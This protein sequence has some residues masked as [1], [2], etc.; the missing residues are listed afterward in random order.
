MPS[1]GVVFPGDGRDPGVRSGVPASLA[2]GLEQAGARVTHVAADPPA[3]LSR[4]TLNA[5][6]A[7]HVPQAVGAGDARRSRVAAYN[8]PE[9]GALQ[10]WA[11]GRRVRGRS[12]IDGFVQVGSSYSLPGDVRFVTHDDMTVVQAARAEYPGVTSISKRA[13]DAR[14][15]RQRLA[16]ERAVA[17]C[18]VTRWAAQSIVEDYGIPA[19]KVCVVGGGRNHEPRVVDRDWSTPRFLFVGK[20]WERKN[21]PAVLEAFGRLRREVPDARLDVVGHHPPIDEPGVVAHGPLGLGDADGRRR[22]DEL[23]ESA[24]CFVMPSRHDPSGIVFSEA[25]CAGIPSIGSTEGG[26]GE[27]IGDA[28]CVVHPDDGDGLLDAMRRL[29]DPATAERLG[30]NAARR[31]RLFTWQKVGER[32]IRALQPPDVETKTLAEFL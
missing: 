12:G 4:L 3:P 27:L 22:V 23:F 6:T 24:T 18:V 25:N 15:E 29:A 28:G 7:L 16:F 2:R 32:V 20:D 5:L 19:G 26:S 14:I 31:S 30:A 17:C 21:G 9:M 10:T 1:I 11:A 13:L 8:R